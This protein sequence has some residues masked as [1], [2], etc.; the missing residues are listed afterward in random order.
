MS[1][2][3]SSAPGPQELEKIRSEIADLLQQKTNAPLF[4][5]LAFHDAF[6]YDSSSS[7]GGANGS[8]RNEKELEHPGNEGLQEAVAALAAVKEKHPS[9]SHA[10]D[11]WTRTV[12]FWLRHHL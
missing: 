4:L 9:L 8:I 7:T 5:R 6:T 11:H 3:S 1:R 10:G 12:G 2:T